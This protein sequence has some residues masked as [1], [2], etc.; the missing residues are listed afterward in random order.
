MFCGCYSLISLDL[1]NFNTQN[2]TNMK[3]MFYF[4]N[5][6]ILLNL[7]FFNSI[8][9]IDMKLNLKIMDMFEG[10]NSLFYKNKTFI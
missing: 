9:V 4:R 5:S 6:L 10:C 3:F 8:N 2:L 1:S 7:S